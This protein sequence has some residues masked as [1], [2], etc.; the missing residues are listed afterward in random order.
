[1]AAVLDW[2]I[3]VILWLQQFSPALD[4]L[5][6]ALTFMGE[7]EF[8][9]V[10]LPLIYWCLDRRNGLRVVVIFLFSAYLNGVAKVVANQPRPFEYDARVRQLVNAPG[11][12]LP[13]GHTQNTVVI[14]GY[15]AAQLRRR[16]LWVV[17][18]LLIV[19]IPLSRLYTG[20]HFPTDLL[21]GYVLGAA[22]LGLALWW[23]PP[24]ERWLAAR[25]LAWQLGLTA[26]VAVLLAVLFRTEDGA[27]IAGVLLGL[28]A[29]AAL[30]RRW[31]RFAVPGRWWQL[32]ARAVL[33]VAVLL[34]LRFG[35]KAVFAG[36]EPLLLFRYVR[37]ACLGLWAALGAP[38]AFVKLRLAEQ[39]TTAA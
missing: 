39:K 20:V 34:G 26:V 38:W 4:G 11:G 7:E 29:G 15:L 17:A 32:V 24:V 10:L 1:M 5:F 23:V 36:L 27:A 8:F 16:W 22:V 28:G 35:L 3:K 30:E 21:G 12:G 31:V 18:G 9:L 14:W 33:G 37:Y 25:S 2:G 19:L 6:K 13:S